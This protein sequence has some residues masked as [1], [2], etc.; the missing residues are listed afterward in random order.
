MKFYKADPKYNYWV[1]ILS[2]KLNAIYCN[3]FI[4]FFKNANQHNT[5]NAALISKYLKV[6]VFYLNGQCYGTE[7]QFTKQSW[8][9]FCKLKAFL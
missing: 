5:K 2:N 1:N 7:K 3:G 9:K 4:R 8:R 6:K